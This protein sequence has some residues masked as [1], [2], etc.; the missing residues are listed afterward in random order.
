MIVF[1]NSLSLPFVLLPFILS[2]NSDAQITRSEFVQRETLDPEDVRFN[3]FFFNG[4]Y[5]P[6]GFKPLLKKDYPISGFTNSTLR[7]SDA[8]SVITT[9]DYEVVYNVPRLIQTIGGL[10]SYPDS[11]NDHFWDVSSIILH[12]YSIVS[13]QHM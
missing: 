11:R 2:S 4:N 10:P 6:V 9:D 12:I 7:L 3:K 5:N 13:Q 1:R 8:Y